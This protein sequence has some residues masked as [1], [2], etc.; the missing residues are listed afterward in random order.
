MIDRAVCQENRGSPNTSTVLGAPG[1]PN[2]DGLCPTSAKKKQ[3]NV[4]SEVII[5][6]V[7]GALPQFSAACQQCEVDDWMHDRQIMYGQYNG[8]RAAC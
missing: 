7:C 1:R 2:L 8:K 5:L 6:N 3:Q 4:K